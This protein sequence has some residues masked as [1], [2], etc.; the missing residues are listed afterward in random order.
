MKTITTHTDVYTFREL[1]PEAQKRA[2]DDVRHNEYYPGDFYAEDTI[3]QFVEDIKKEGWE[4]DTDDVQY[5]GFW[6]QGDGASFDAKLDVYDY[7]NFHC[8]TDKFPLITKLT[9]DGPYVWGK[10]ETNSY[11]NHYCHERTRYF[12]IDGESEDTWISDGGITEDQLPAV[13]AEMEALEKDI[14]ARRLDLCQKLYRDLESE[15]D[16]LM[17]DESITDFIISNEYEFTLN[18]KQY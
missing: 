7:L 18:G 12:Q 6:S 3:E 2:I 15:Y 14:E 13:R 5:S 8:L 17:S 1:P 10:T 4:L 9:T 11:S 16:S